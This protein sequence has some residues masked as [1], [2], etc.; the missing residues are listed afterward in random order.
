MNRFC[1]EC[2]TY[3]VEKEVRSDVPA[4]ACPDCGRE[5]P[6]ARLPLLVVGGASGVGKSTVRR[7]LLGEV[8][9]TVILDVDELWEPA[10][11]DIE[12]SF[13][14]N[15]YYLRQCK[16][17]AQSGQPVT[18][19]GAELGMPGT[20]E[21]S[22]QRRYFSEVHYLA[23]ICDEDVQAERLAARSN[24]AVDERRWTEIDEQLALNR[25]YR[26]RGR[27]TT[28][29]IKTV[30]GTDRTVT[31]VATEVRTWIEN[32][33]AAAHWNTPGS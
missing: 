10:F 9:D 16:Q 18:I 15:T 14:Y 23:L 29:P 1:P 21:E 12:E 25:W 22:V 11:N 2:G 17:I 31:D 27:N 6:F 33:L 7:E 20:V 30:D 4:V 28:S 19:F 8:D 32:T 13:D 3:T 26:R 5:E 24:W